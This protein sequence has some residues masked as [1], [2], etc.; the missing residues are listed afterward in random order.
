MK[1]REVKMSYPAND[2]KAQWLWDFLKHSEN[3]FTSRIN[4]FLVAESMLMVSYATVAN[5]VSSEP[6]IMVVIAAL[7]I[8]F[9]GAWICVNVRAFNTMGDVAEKVKATIP[10]YEEIR[11]RRIGLMSNV[12]LG[13]FL[14][15][16]TLAA[17]IVLFIFNAYLKV[18]LGAMGSG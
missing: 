16:I 13:F 1:K 4:F 14:P 7:G 17:W 10:L 15:C 18:I 12:I 5:A 6:L 3:T 2:P 9:T 8:L 11:D